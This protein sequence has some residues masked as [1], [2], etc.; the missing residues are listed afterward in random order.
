MH[1]TMN[2]RKWKVFTA[3]YVPSPYIKQISFVFR[4][5][6][7]S[8]IEAIRNIS[9]KCIRPVLASLARHYEEM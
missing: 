4:R 7:S 6:L 3:R 8:E 9:W 1:G 5:L 2:I